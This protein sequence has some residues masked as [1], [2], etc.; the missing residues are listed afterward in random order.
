MAP[1]DLSQVLKELRDLRKELRA[2]AKRLLT[3][4]ETAHYL[5][6]A[7][8]TV[9]NSLGPKAARAFPV[10]PVR[11]AGRVLFRLEDLQKYVDSLE[12]DA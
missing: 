1:P 6:L 4:D 10:K 2:P 9:R 8:K 12:A 5:G 11:V 7:P 3:V